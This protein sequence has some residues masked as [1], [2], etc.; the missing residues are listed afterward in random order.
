[1][2]KLNRV[3]QFLALAAVVFVGRPDTALAANL[4][5]TQ[6]SAPV[7]QPLLITISGPGAS[8]SS[9]SIT[10]T[11]T[12]TVGTLN[13]VAVTQ[14]GGNWL[15]AVPSGATLTVSVGPAACPSGVTTSQLQSNVSYNGQLNVT[16]S[17]GNS[18]NL[19][20][21]VQ[22]G[23]TSGGTG[24]V[25][26]QNPVSFS[27]PSGSSSQF[28]TVNITY[29][30]AAQTV[31]SVSTSTNTFSNWL[32][33]TNLGT[34][35]QINVTPT[36]LTSGSGSDTGTVT[37][38]T[39]NGNLSITVNL[40]VGG[41]GTTGLA[42]SPNPLTF[43]VATG[44]GSTS[45]PVSITNSGSPI[46]STVTNISTNTGSNWLSAF[47]SGSTVTVTAN[48]SI[49][50]AGS[51]SGTVTVSTSAGSLNFTVNLNIG[52]GSTSGLVASPNPLN[53][54]LQFGSSSTSQ[55]VAITFNG[56]PAT[57]TGVSASTTT[58]QSW[59]QATN[60]LTQGS[61]SVT[62]NPTNLSGT[63]T[64]TVTV[65]TTNGSLPFTVTL[66][67]GSG[68]TSGLVATPTAI[69][70]NITLPGSGAPTQ[71]VTI[72]N[73]GIPVTIQSIVPNINGTWLLASN[74]SPGV[75]TLSCNCANLTMGTYSGTV[76]VNTSSGPIT[77]QVNANIGQ[78]SGSQ[79]LAVSPSPLS[80]SVAVGAATTTQNVSVTYNGTPVTINSVSTSTTTG[81]NWLQAS[82]TGI[83]GSVA[84]TVNPGFLQAGGY[85]GN[86]TINTQNGTTSLVVNL[87]VGS[88]GTSGL[89]V[90]PGMVSLTATSAGIVNPQNV[91]V[92]L[93]GNPVTINSVT[94]TTTT[95]QNWLA[96]SF[97]PSVPG[98]VT[99]NA[100]TTGLAAGTYTGTVTVTTLNGQVSFQVTL[101]VGGGTTGNGLV[102]SPNPIAFTES[103]PG[104]APP[105][106]VSV[107]LNGAP[108]PILTTTFTPTQLGLT[109]VNT[110]VNADGTATLT[111]NNV[112]TTQGIYTGSLT[113]YLTSGGSAIVPVT[114]TFGTGGGTGGLAA[115]PNPVN[116]NIPAGGAASTQNVSITSNGALVTVSNVN[117]STTTGQ[118]WLQAATTSSLGGISV[119]ANPFGLGSGSYS[120]TVLVTTTSGSLSIPVNLTVGGSGQA[121]ITL[122]TTSLS[123]AYQTGQ[124]QPPSQSVTLTA[125]GGAQVSF[126]AVASTTTTP[127]WLSIIP[128]SGIVGV[129]IAP[130]SITAS[131]NAAGLAAGTYTG[132]IAVTP[133]GGSPQNVTVTLTVTTP[134]V[135]TPTVV[136][137]QNAASSIPTAVSPGLN[138]L[139]FGL[140][141]GPATLT[142]YVVGPNGAL[143]TT[144]AGTQ[145]TFDG[146]AAAIIYTRNT[147]VSVMV[148]YEI[149][150][151]VSTAMV[152]I[153]NGVSST[154]L[155][156]R[157]VDT[158]PGIYT[159][160][161][162]G[163]GQ[164]AIL[165]QNGSVNGTG[166]PES[167][168]NYI[169]IFGTG[170]GQTSP[171]GVN[172]AILPSRLPLPVPN[173]AVTVTIGGVPVSAADINYAGEA[174][175]EISG[176]FQVNAKIPPGVGPGAVPVVIRWGGVASQ[177]NVTV[178]V[179]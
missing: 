82:T 169:Q 165:N 60:S 2:H 52:S 54:N 37:V 139:I 160:T 74:T 122:S 100:S 57:I 177:A 101:S 36:N 63:Y 67:V 164:G 111:V 3:V 45:L 89:V 75:V 10:V 79:G 135:T 91:T 34:S 73:N 69:N 88:G 140:N 153:Y 5:F 179:R 162:T 1:V 29:F 81:Q 173:A 33:A 124:A 143:A 43:T 61:V 59:L 133:T 107:T 7:Q 167:V 11:S 23:A 32:S 94:S 170:E 71:T 20:V 51:Y 163:S 46:S 174:P 159:L 6:N 103:T 65:N 113:I 8:N 119:T 168:G 78:G 58:G 127:S 70:F 12:A 156:L 136:A 115:S 4:N 149:A 64:G 19:A 28:T 151:R 132:T 121:S 155:Q 123:F 42:A 55:N 38:V 90:T 145:V 171:A 53:F 21:T 39:P 92:S 97:T 147:L 138:I 161:Q 172:G 137:V 85:T 86:V 144:V 110:V 49:L 84:I 41:G 31:T 99:I 27:V 26:S 158:A 150:G 44:A 134:A 178:S 62:V 96:T 109:F 48:P 22:V 142:P 14:S 118:S 16:D 112:I 93:N 80:L 66:T 175:G 77:F 154:P 106:I 56:Q 128:T 152:V 108:Q 116:F 157:V 18:G 15:C 72:T 83:T 120:G 141:M 13:P 9:A 131:V 87:T 146:V 126:T 98:T 102:V 76:M 35:V 130:A 25:A 114:L 148:P 104:A 176:V 50:T 47:S 24:L 30:G 125:A 17:N 40:T 166:N 105:Q 68:N 95:G 129:G 117:T